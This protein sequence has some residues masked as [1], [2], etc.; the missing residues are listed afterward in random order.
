MESFKCPCNNLDYINLESL[1]IHQK[2]NL[3]KIPI[4]L[5]EKINERKTRGK[6]VKSRFYGL[7]GV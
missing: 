1:L 7:A 2:S 3:H 4:N 6:L 5:E